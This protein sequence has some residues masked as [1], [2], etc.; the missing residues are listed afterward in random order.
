MQE[1]LSLVQ[2][3]GQVPGALQRLFWFLELSPE[4]QTQVRE[5]TRVSI[6]PAALVWVMLSTVKDIVKSWSH[7]PWMHLK[8]V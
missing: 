3:S 6:A 2:N 5:V 4:T 1:T 8:D 7:H